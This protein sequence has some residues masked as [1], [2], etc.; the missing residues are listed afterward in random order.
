MTH[1]P[2]HLNKEITL[3]NVAGILIRIAALPLKWDGILRFIFLESL[4]DGIDKPF[5]YWR[6]PEVN[7]IGQPVSQDRMYAIGKTRGFS[8][9]LSFLTIY[10]PW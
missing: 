1:I 4:L 7:R 3:S 9:S 2:K 6:A 8:R 5:Q 10:A